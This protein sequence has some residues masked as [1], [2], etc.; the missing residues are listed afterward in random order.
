MR[1]F[2]KILSMSTFRPYGTIEYEIADG[3]DTFK[4]VL[5]FNTKDCLEF[6]PKVGQEV[7]FELAPFKAVSIRELKD[8]GKVFLVNFERPGGKA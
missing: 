5:K 6:V 1:Y 7:S 8:H 2:G 4:H 3:S